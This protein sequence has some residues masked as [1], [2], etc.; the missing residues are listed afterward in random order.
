M[1]TPKIRRNLLN[2]QGFFGIV[3][4]YHKDVS[5]GKAGL[6]AVYD[7]AHIKDGGICNKTSL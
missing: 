3:P 2:P 6:L 7:A 1:R 5:T 4:S